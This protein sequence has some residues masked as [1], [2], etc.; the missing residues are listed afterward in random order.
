MAIIIQ[1][2]RSTPEFR[3]PAGGE[4]LWYGIASLIPTGYVIDSYCSNVFVR[5]AAGGGANNTPAG[6]HSHGHS[7]PANSGQAADHTHSLGGG[8]T[9][10][11]YGETEV[12]PSG[13]VGYAPGGHTHSIN[14]GTSGAAGNHSHSLSAAAAAEVYPPFKRL[15]WIKATMDVGLPVG[16]ILMWDRPIGSAPDGCQICNGSDDTPDLRDKFIYGAA[17]DGDVGAG[18]GTETHVHANPDSGSAGAHSHSYT[19]GTGGAPSSSG[20]SGYPEGTTVAG[21]G[22][23]HTMSGNTPGEAGHSHTIGNTG[24]GSSLPPFLKLYFI[25]RTV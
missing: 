6:S 1:R 14:S 15:Y 24:A 4:I 22:H 19:V 10:A 2:R 5:G 16:G 18:G 8:S 23:T 17:S 7:N 21:G 25:M 3:I 9:T 13:S 12:Y 11:A 20:V